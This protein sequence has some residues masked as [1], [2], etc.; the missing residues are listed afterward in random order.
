MYPHQPKGSDMKRGK[1]VV[2]A[3]HKG[4]AGKTTIAVNLAHYACKTGLKTLIVDLDPQANATDSFIDEVESGYE[5]A[6]M[7]FTEKQPGEVKYVKANMAII[8]SD[9][10]KLQ[11]V[12]SEHGADSAKVFQKRLQEI[13]RNFDIVVV[14]TPPTLGFGMLAPLMAADYAFS[15]LA[16]DAYGM[17]GIISL[18]EQVTL[19]RKSDNPNLQY[20]G[21]LI[22]LWNKRSKHQNRQVEEFRNELGNF[23]IPWE[24]RNRAAIA[25]AAQENKAVWEYTKGE[26]AKEIKNALA[27]ILDRMDSNEKIAA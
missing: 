20:I 11:N 10:K 23:L 24:I 7:L 18:I 19:I 6:S 1:I 12:E 8:P 25:D 27:Y 16:P 5:H 9:G 13:A 15:P 17:K 3:I 14:D 26:A 22:N 21:V 2:C 4:G